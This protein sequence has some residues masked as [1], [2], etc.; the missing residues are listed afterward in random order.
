MGGGPAREE[1]VCGCGL[2]SENVG[3]QDLEKQK[4]RARCRHL[5]IFSISLAGGV[6]RGL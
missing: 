2:F 6:G 5:W 1:Y 4:V 3:H